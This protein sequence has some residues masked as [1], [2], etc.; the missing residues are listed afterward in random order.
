M[1]STGTFVFL[2]K[3]KFRLC[4]VPAMVFE[5]LFMYI[6]Q[7]VFQSFT[8]GVIVN[9]LIALAFPILIVTTD[10][11]NEFMDNFVTTGFYFFCVSVSVCRHS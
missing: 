1:I 10:K 9:I 2:T 8:P 11:R 6:S 5:T 4:L 7:M 3:R